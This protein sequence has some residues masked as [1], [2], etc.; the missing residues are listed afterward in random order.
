MTDTDYPPR[1]RTRPR[2]R[3]GVADPRRPGRGL[4][5]HRTARVGGRPVGR[6][7]R[8]GHRGPADPCAR[9]RRR[10]RQPRR[11]HGRGDRPGGR[12][13]A[14]RVASAALARVRSSTTA[15]S[16]AAPWRS[17][18][19]SRALITRDRP[20]VEI[21]D[22]GLVPDHSFPSGHVATSVVVYVAHSPS[23]SR[24]TVARC[25]PLDVAAVPRPAGRRREPALPGRAPPD[26]RADQPGLRTTVGRGRRPR[27][28]AGARFRAVTRW[29]HDLS[30]T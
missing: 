23:T 19:S 4:A 25:A 2:L 6:Q 12:H 16:S 30:H 29:G 15:C 8:A 14:G 13:R 3:L 10:R 7:R 1:R 27:G 24:R 17:T 9:R 26:G 22:P 20:P 11:R 21:L 28:A 18:S 5:A